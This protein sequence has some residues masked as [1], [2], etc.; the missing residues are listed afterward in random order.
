MNKE[1]RRILVRDAQKLSA[2]VHIGKNGVS[3]EVLRQIDEAIAHH[4]LLKVKLYGQ[5]ELIR[6]VATEVSEKL[7]IHLIEVRGFTAVF[8][9]QQEDP[10]KQRYPRIN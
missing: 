7:N 8:Y 1:D 6:E 10:A 4:E 9:K 3:D 2:I 5:K